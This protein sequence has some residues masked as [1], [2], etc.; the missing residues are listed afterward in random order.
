[1]TF[2]VID[3]MT[4]ARENDKLIGEKNLRGKQRHAGGRS[5]S[6]KAAALSRGSEAKGAA[7]PRPSRNPSESPPGHPCPARDPQRLK[8]W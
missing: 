3:P 6:T 7:R 8:S 4:P 5:A 1:M 2:R